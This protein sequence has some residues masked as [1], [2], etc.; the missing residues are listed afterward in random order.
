MKE[1]FFISG[2]PRSGST[3]LSGILRQNPEFYADISSP[4][5]GLAMSTINVITGS[6]NNHVIDEVRRKQILRSVF[7][8]YYQAVDRPTVFDTSRG[9]TSKNVIAQG[10]IPANQNYLLCARHTLDTG[11]V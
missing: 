7:D 1:Y 2:L 10:A 9:W 4:M 8:A 3:L 11:F 5:Q 6:E